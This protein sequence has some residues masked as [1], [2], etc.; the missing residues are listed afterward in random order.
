MILAAVAALVG[1]SIQSGTGFGFALIL[2]PALAAVL[3]P[4]EAI[5]ALLVLGFALNVLTLLGEGGD[6]GA[7]RWRAVAPM[8][9]AALPG[10]GAGALLLSVISKPALQLSVGGAVVL[11]AIGQAWSTPATG[12]GAAHD[13]SLRSA[14]AVGLVTGAL[15]TSTMVSGPPLVLWFQSLRMRPGELRASL[16]ASF[17]ALSVAGAALL[18]AAGALSF[19]ARVVLP[20]LALI[21]LGHLLGARLL[22]GLDPPRLRVAVLALVMAAGAASL[23]AGIAGL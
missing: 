15:T 8:L 20:L 1:A 3:D 7:V 5:T 9:A 13:P 16:A 23:A 4:Y 22:R 18:A 17:L 11:A 6:P 2:S 19:D 12:D 10:L 14:S 21:A